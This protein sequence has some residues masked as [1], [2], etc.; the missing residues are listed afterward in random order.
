[1]ECETCDTEGF[2]YDPNNS[3]CDSCDQETSWC[4]GEYQAWP[5]TGHW[6][7]SWTSSDIHTCQN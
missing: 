3:T 7:S 2:S 5:K 1:M 4:L 6:Q